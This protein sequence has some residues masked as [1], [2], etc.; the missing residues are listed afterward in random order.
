[1]QKIPLSAIPN[2]SF[3]VILDNQ[4][5]VIHLYQRGDYMYMDLTVNGQVVRTGM[6]CLVDVSIVNYPVNGFSGYLFFSDLKGSNG[7]VN[8]AELDSRYI[9]LYVTEDELDV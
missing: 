7:I 6:I 5:C 4:N 9:L 1:M 3:N 2:Q 8:Y